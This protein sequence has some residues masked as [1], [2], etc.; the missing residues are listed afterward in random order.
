VRFVDT[1]QRAG[2]AIEIADVFATPNFAGLGRH[3][4]REAL[5][6]AGAQH[7]PAINQ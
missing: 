3:V 1:A 5:V 6:P 7:A 2:F 4:V